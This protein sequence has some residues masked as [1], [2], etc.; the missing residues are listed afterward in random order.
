MPSTWNFYCHTDVHLGKN[1][2]GIRE[3]LEGKTIIF[4]EW[5]NIKAVYQIQSPLFLSTYLRGG[6]SV[7]LINGK[8]TEAR[9]Y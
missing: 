2:A 3:R 1:M 7:I 9:R 8:Q 4:C 5:D 6:F